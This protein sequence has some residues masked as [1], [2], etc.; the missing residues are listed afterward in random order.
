MQNLIKSIELFIIFKSIDSK[1]DNRID[2]TE[3]KYNFCNLQ[4]CGWNPFENT[5]Y[6]NVNILIPKVGD[7][8][9]SNGQVNKDEIEEIDEEK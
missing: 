4:E 2:L 1:C 5:K 7:D 8:L 3:F 9:M 6:T